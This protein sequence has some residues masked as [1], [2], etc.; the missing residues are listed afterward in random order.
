MHMAAIDTFDWFRNEIWP[1]AT[2]ELKRFFQDRREYL[3][4]IRN[5]NERRRFIEGLMLEVKATLK[6]QRG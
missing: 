3:L 6:K 1:Q 4:N 5:E 2:D